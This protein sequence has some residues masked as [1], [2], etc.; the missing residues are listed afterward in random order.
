M[1]KSTLIGLV[2]GFSAVGV[3][4]VLKG[5]SLVALWNPAA[6]MIIFVGT[7]AA[8]FNAF[9]MEELKR[10]PKLFKIIF[11]GPKITPKKEIVHTFVALATTARRE[12]LLS[13]E[14]QLESIEDPFIRNG[15]QLVIDGG[16]SEYVRS[17]LEEEIYATE[18]RHRSGAL[19]F[20]Q[21]GT[22]AP[23]LGVL[24]AVIGLIAALGNLSDIE[25][26][27]HSIA[28]AFVATLLGIFSG[29]VLWH[30]IANKLKRISSREI[31]IKQMI[32]EGVLA[33]QAGNSPLAI[34]QM[35]LVYL[36]VSERRS[37]REEK[38]VQEAQGA[39]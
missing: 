24:G 21:A 22:Y 18:E 25:K 3:G 32:M 23:T 28:A 13:L 16:D 14:S 1:E 12:G 29:Y 39:A 2:L 10:I 7:T 5:A 34:E 31:E 30:P 15:M 11:Q 20:S 35:L 26:L 19:I 8:V 38:N 27:G 17:L 6:L 33:I 4:M 36:P 9:P 37:E